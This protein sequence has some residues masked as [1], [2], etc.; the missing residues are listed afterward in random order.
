MSTSNRSRGHRP[1]CC[2]FSRRGARVLHARGENRNPSQPS[3]AAKIWCFRLKGPMGI[4][5]HVD[6]TWKLRVVCEGEAA[7]VSSDGMKTSASGRSAT[8][9]MALSAP[10]IADYHYHEL[11]LN[12][13]RPKGRPRWQLTAREKTGGGNWLLVFLSLHQELSSDIDRPSFISRS[14]SAF[15]L[16]RLFSSWS[17]AISLFFLSPNPRRTKPD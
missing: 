11:Y 14:T 8:T 5:S 10:I 13:P 2:D 9:P 15:K 1:H 4:K 16:V 17:I 3:F 7:I 6:Y 12:V